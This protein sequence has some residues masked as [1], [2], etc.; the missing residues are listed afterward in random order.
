MVRCCLEKSENEQIS[1]TT[2]KQNNEK[3]MNKYF[4]KENSVVFIAGALH[5]SSLTSSP[6]A[7]SH[8]YLFI[9]STLAWLSCVAKNALNLF[10]L[11]QRW[12]QRNVPPHPIYEVLRSEPRVLCIL[13]R[14]PINWT[15]SPGSHLTFRWSLV[16]QVSK[17]DPEIMCTHL[18]DQCQSSS[19]L[20]YN[21]FPLAIIHNVLS[22]CP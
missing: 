18:V 15:P 5:D 8:P 13:G 14:C 11:S 16:I 3:T 7:S 20:L 21:L 1:K 10:S 6:N 4:G 17:R 19:S 2:N 12:D 9:G 22:V